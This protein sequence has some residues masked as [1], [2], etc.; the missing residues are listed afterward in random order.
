MKYS[1]S[2]FLILV[3]MVCW[4]ACQE[5][6]SIEDPI[7][8]ISVQ[9]DGVTDEPIPVQAGRRISFP[10]SILGATSFDVVCKADNGWTATV[11]ATSPTS[12]ILRIRAPY[13]YL[14]GTITLMVTSQEGPTATKTLSFVEQESSPISF[15]YVDDPNMLDGWSELLVFS[16]GTF[17]MGKTDS[18]SDGYVLHVGNMLEESSFLAYFDKDDVLREIYTGE[19]I[20]G[21]AEVNSNVIEVNYT[22]EQK[23][24]QSARLE[25]DANATKSSGGMPS[26]KGFDSDRF[27][28]GFKLLDHV[29]ATKEAVGLLM[30]AKN[31]GLV[32]TAGA[33]YVLHHIDGVNSLLDVVF[34]V[35]VSKKLNADLF[36]ELAEDI[37]DLKILMS[38]P[39]PSGLIMIYSNLIIKYYE[40][41]NEHI[42]AYYGNC[43]AQIDHVNSDQI[44]VEIIVNVS[45]HENWQNTLEVGV[46]IGEMVNPSFKE[47]GD[48][49]AITHNGD[50]SF[51][52]SDLKYWTRYHCRPFV[53][54]KSR[55]AL[56]IGCLGKISGPFV[57][58]GR[59]Y[60]FSTPL[61]KATT[62][63]PIDIGENTAT[64][65]VKFE[66]VPSGASCGV[67]IDETRRIP[68]SPNSATVK[69]S[70]LEAAT[71]YSYR[72][73]VDYNGETFYG[74]SRSFSTKYP[75]V[76]GIWYC[77]EKRYRS[78][79]FEPYYEN[80][81]VALHSDG[82]AEW[83]KE[84][85]SY[86]SAT[87]TQHK[88]GLEVNIIRYSSFS[89]D[90][91]G[92][93]SITFDD[94]NHP[95]QGIGNAIW[96]VYNSNTG[97]GSTNYYELTMKR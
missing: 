80:Y 95:T 56:W 65:E 60:S 24:I 97:G 96:W 38:S 82:T 63:D 20:F 12:G 47:R 87:W 64:V 34:G 71:E 57:R 52:E 62:G 36:F 21:F 88:Y 67:E 74:A 81:S 37:T 13:P 77:T 28:S 17:L 93:L 51:K 46:A 70:E 10:Y 75:D 32:L 79:T 19:A 18:D 94:F 54:D 55:D 23:G 76:T 42:E 4:T 1:Q 48:I 83:F 69:V 92:S 90:Q 35:D 9:I 72:A 50:Y 86:E 16:D 49:C 5:K 26:V 44:P 84:D 11:E 91:G 68:A 59:D 30:I 15:S 29:L 25:L 66:N 61:P 8:T 31:P 33:S 40:L 22:S 14:D 39:T 73:Y 53:V 43:E 6:M 2:L 45:G 3:G 78:F 27:I 7:S 89:S 85:S 41:Y 58:Y